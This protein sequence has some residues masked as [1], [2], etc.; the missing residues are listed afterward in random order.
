MDHA[1]SFPTRIAFRTLI[2]ILAALSTACG[3]FGKT[4]DRSSAMNTPSPRIETLFAK[5][6]PVCFG[7]FVIDVPETAQVVWGPSQVND[8]ISSYPG[9]GH[10]LR[11]EIHDKVTEIKAIKHLKEPSTLLG[12]FDGP[13]P[14]ARSSWDTSRGMI[15]ASSSSI[16]TFGWGSTPSFRAHQAPFWEE[17]M[18][19]L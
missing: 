2:L 1:L 13:I 15:P 19:A 11:G 12:V 10:R 7:R 8:D 5:T 6:K 17:T 18:R 4:S 9:E 3:D 16:P 14:R